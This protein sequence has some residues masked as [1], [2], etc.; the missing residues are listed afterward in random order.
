MILRYDSRLCLI[1]FLLL[2]PL[3]VWA[4]HQQHIVKRGDTLYSLGRTY[5]MTVQEIQDLNG[6]RDTNL[7]I[8]QVL[9]MKASSADR[10][11][12]PEPGIASTQT[13]PTSPIQ[14]SSLPAS[15]F[16]QIKRGDNLYRISREHDISVR[17]IVKWNGFPDANV[18]IYPGQRIIIKDPATAT[19]GADTASAD[20]TQEPSSAREQTTQPEKTYIV[21]PKDTLYRIARENNMSVA[22]L[23]QL[24]SLTGNDL[25]V[26]QKIYLAGKPREIDQATIDRLNEAELLTKD[27]IRDDLAVVV[28]GEVISEYG[29]RN[30]RPHK[31]IDIAAK[32][33][34]PIYAVLDGT[35]VYSGAQ[36]AYGNVVVLEH[37][38]FVM[39][40]Y[41][42]NEKNLVSVGDKVTKGQQIATV[43]S[44]G[45]ASGS[46]LH[47]EYRIK[48]KAVNP[49]KVLPLEKG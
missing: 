14:R 39:T 3:M 32:S 28:E 47:F 12:V 7:S 30:G 48:G 23:K 37:P 40:V 10:A 36:G 29:L 33:G 26:G 25:R 5:G 13:S 22:E 41:A 49:R 42:H 27:R 16:Y 20:E 19:P 15:H 6:L 43:G 38:K 24:N 31:G 9:K 34:T 1:L 44:T 46:H 45:N 2:L 21:Q 8:G 4:Q 18:P 11:T 35:V 17:D